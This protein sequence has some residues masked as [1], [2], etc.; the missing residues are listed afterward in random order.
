MSEKNNAWDHELYIFP[1]G[2]I[3]V[4]GSKPNKYLLTINDNKYSL[5]VNE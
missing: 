2:N 5:V 3:Y 4:Y 1:L